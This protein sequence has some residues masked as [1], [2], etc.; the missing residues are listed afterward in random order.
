MLLCRQ[1]QEKGLM[2]S[3]Y[4]TKKK[5]LRN[6]IDRLFQGTTFVYYIM[7]CRLVQVVKE[8]YNFQSTC[9]LYERI[10]GRFNES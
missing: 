7:I 1:V 3:F 4:V 5:S 8:D 2:F 10:W 9:Q 6:N